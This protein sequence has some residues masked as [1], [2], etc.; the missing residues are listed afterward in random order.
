[1][2]VAASA[3]FDLVKD[4]DLM[5][6]TADGEFPSWQPP[7]LGLGKASIAAILLVGLIIAFCYWAAIS[8]APKPVPQ[9]IQVTQATLTQLPKPTPPPPPKVIPPPKPVP[10]IIP[11]PA[12]VPS[13]IAVAVKPPPPVHHVFKPVPHP[14]INHAPPPPTP[15][16]V[17]QA[18]QPPAPPTSGIPIYGSQMHDIIQANQSVP[19]ALA[20]LGVSGTAYILIVVAPDGHVISARVSKS[21]GIPLI[22]QTALQHAMEAHLPPFNGEMPS[23]PQQY[24]IPVEIDGTDS[25]N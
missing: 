10:A 23:A 16:P 2:Q 20:Q 4:M 5:S 11:K 14:V 9:A 13:K 19:P 21:S 18:P 7:E 24:L 1:L 8:M 22:D 17:S 3:F 25:G 15:A 6:T 12:P